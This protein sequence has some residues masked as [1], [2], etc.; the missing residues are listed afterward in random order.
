MLNTNSKIYIAGHTGLL[1]SALLRIMQR[2]GYRN[3]ITRLHKELDLTDPNRVKD[4]FATE[5]P[6]YVFL[7]AGRVG[8]IVG[9]KTYPADFLHTNISIQDNVFEAAYQNEVRNLV[10]YGSSCTYPKHCK[11]PMNENDWLN[12]SIEPTSRAYAAAKIAGIIGCASYNTQHHSNRFIALIPNSMYGLNDN[13]DLENAHVLSALIRRFHEAAQKEER[14]ITLWGSGL[15][16]REFIFSEDVAEASIFAVKNVE[17]LENRHYNIGTGADISI[18]ELAQKISEITHYEGEI[19]WDTSM[20]DGAPRKLL[21]SSD[22]LEFGWR[23]TKDFDQ[24]LKETYEW[25]KNTL[26]E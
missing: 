5:K 11:Q 10:F 25:F 17:K 20:P 2:D 19:I 14:S 21:D 13:F 18:D 7:A 9:N 4:F 3:I 1:G 8:G 24:G 23:P 22:F 6:E 26:K 12:G 15:P 16:R